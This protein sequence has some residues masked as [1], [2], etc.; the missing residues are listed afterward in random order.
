MNCN[1]GEAGNTGSIPES[2]KSPGRGHGNPLQYSCLEK[3]MD[4]EASWATIYRVTQSEVKS[5]G[6]HMTE[7]TK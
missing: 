7:V 3:S 4:R 6:S 1:V 2:R 5:I